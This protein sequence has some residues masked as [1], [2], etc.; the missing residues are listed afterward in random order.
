MS[1]EFPYL[2]VLT[3]IAVV[4]LIL[5]LLTHDFSLACWVFFAVYWLWVSE[6]WRNEALSAQDELRKLTNTT[7]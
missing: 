3:L 6:G 2:F 4:R 1:N 7:P 5:A